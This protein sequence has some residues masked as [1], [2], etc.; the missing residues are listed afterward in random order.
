MYPRNRKQKFAAYTDGGWSSNYAGEL[1]RPY[2]AAALMSGVTLDRRTITVLENVKYKV[3]LAEIGTTDLLQASTCDFTLA[4]DTSIDYSERVLTLTD[5]QVNAKLCKNTWRAQWDAVNM[6][7]G[8]L[9]DNIAP[10]ISSFLLMHIAG[11]VAEEIEYHVWQGDTGGASYTKFNGLTTIADA[12]GASTNLYYGGAG[13]APS[14]NHTAIAA[15][16]GGGDPT[17]ASEVIDVFENFLPLVPT[18][19][20]QA[21]DFT[22]YCNNKVLFALRRAQAALGFKDDYYERAGEFTSFLGYKVAPAYG[23][24]DTHLVAGRASNIFFGTDLMA[25]H[26]E[27]NVIDMALT[28]G[29]NHARIV[30]QLSGGTQIG[31][32]LDYFQYEYSA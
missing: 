17:D 28:T 12:L 9:G 10:N 24:Q 13:A 16:A 21:S 26:N 23:L 18:R 11:Q 29:D 2:I 20:L 30:M 14:A 6:G 27:A 5:M 7:A 31:V 8:R 19:V 15:L 22:I 1:A 4:D 32:P 3:N 25:D